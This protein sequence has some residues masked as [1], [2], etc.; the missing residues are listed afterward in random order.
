MLYINLNWDR[1]TSNSCKCSY[2]FSIFR[3]TSYV[4]SVAAKRHF[5]SRGLTLFIYTA[6]VQCIT[7][8]VMT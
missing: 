3:D 8:V 7:Q 5:G 2:K 4:A 1:L 6:V